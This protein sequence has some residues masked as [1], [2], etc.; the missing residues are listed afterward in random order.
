MTPQEMSEV[1]R[2]LCTLAP[3]IPVLVIDDLAHAEPLARALVA[4]GLPV[5]EVTLRTPQALE[6]IALMSKVEGGVVGAGTVLNGEDVSRAKSAGARFA[7]SPGATPDLLSACEAADLPIL[8][9]AATSSEVMA[10]LARG[11]RTAKFF[12]ASTI[13][14]AAGL[15]AIGAPLPQMSFCPTG[16]IT[17]ENARDYLKL[18]NVLCVGGSWVA[19]KAMLEAGDW[20]GI[21]ALAR[22]AAQLKG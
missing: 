2:R 9:G 22:A 8:P 4:G 10:L 3:V 11:Y 14:G 18:S 15:K 19:P 16:G 17:P 5:L 21:T 6:A 13:G 20:E 1:T 7:V 12:P